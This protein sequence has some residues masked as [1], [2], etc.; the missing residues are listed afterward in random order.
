MDQRFDVPLFTP[1]EVADYLWI[2]RTTLRDWLGIVSRLDVAPGHAS[3]PFVGLVE[4]HVIR[5]SPEGWPPAT[6][7]PGG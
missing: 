5:D 7:Y 1:S 6:S 2:K 4:A 3:I